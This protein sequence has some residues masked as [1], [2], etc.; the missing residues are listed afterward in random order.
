[1]RQAVQGD[2]ARFWHFASKVEDRTS[3][4]GCHFLACG[5]LDGDFIVKHNVIVN[6]LRESNCALV[7]LALLCR[8]LRVGEIRSFAAGVRSVGHVG[9]VVG[10]TEV[11]RRLY[12]LTT[13]CIDTTN[14]YICEV[15]YRNNHTFLHLGITLGSFTSYVHS[16]IYPAIQRTAVIYAGECTLPQGFRVA[17]REVG[18]AAEV[19]YL[20]IVLEY[21]IQISVSPTAFFV[22]RP[23]RR[24]VNRNMRKYE[25]RTPSIPYCR[26]GKALTQE[27]QVV[28]TIVSLVAS[29]ETYIYERV[30][31]D[32]EIFAVVVTEGVV[33]FQ[34]VCAYKPFMV[35]HNVVACHVGRQY[36]LVLEH[37][38]ELF[39]LRRLSAV[40]KVAVNYYGVDVRLKR[41]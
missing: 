28:F 40:G 38:A 2:T 18:V 16:R 34:G 10:S 41:V 17:E 23:V 6:G 12:F 5:V 27:F 14:V 19:D 30:S 7:R 36:R 29:R 3:V 32:V 21:V 33:V 39:V 24:A 8:Y 11:P 20:R 4:A 1:M 25:N 31:L 13:M 22:R 35:T 15:F 26:V 37:G 9:A